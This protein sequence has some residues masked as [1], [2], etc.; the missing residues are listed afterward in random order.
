M[1]K[2]VLFAA[3]LES[4]FT[5]F[6]VPQLKYF[7]EQG[8]EV[9]VACGFEGVDIPYCDKK[10][11][12]NFAR[13]LNF[14]QNIQSY[15]QIKEVLKNEK[16]DLISCHTPFGGAIT[17]LAFKNLKI[18][19][20]K[21]VYMAHG[22]HFYKGAPLFN[23]LAYYP[24][25]KY[26][27]KYT[28]AVITI[29][30]DD[31]EIAKKK[32]KT[33]VRLVKGVGLDVSKFDFEMSD[34]E[35]EEYRETLEIKK[36]DFVMIYPA[37]ILP[38]KRQ[39]WL[40]QTLKNTLLENP[41]FKLLLPGK[42]S[43]NGKCHKL[44]K[45]LKLENQVKLLGFRKDIPKLITI[46]DLAVT[47]SMQE[48]LPVNVME[49]MYVGLPIVATACRGNRDLIKNGKNGFV[50]NI[51][52]RKTFIKKVDYFSKLKLEEKEKIK[53]INKEYI[54]PYL[55]DNVLKEIT[56]IYEKK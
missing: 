49:A 30:L 25:E 52:D 46:S 22:F 36:D 24:V 38:R 50:V 53:E 19:D 42:D 23:W 54:K 43:M 10:F 45:D 34:K 15:K 55:L 7:K 27:A 41:N 2:K 32:F 40:M 44:I 9:H 29:N 17:R 20:T 8:Y 39:I 35:K 56:D 37:E 16:Y 6:L 1:V 5:K 51:N 26:L 28:D 3:N 48:G 47:S 4:F 14:K 21:L 11:D 31:Y 18:K 12:V 33:D 13:S